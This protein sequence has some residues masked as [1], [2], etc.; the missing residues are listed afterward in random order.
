MKLVQSIEHSCATLDEVAAMFC[1]SIPAQQDGSIGVSLI[2][3]ENKFP[4]CSSAVII[5]LPPALSSQSFTYVCMQ[6]QKMG[7][8][9]CPVS[10]ARSV[11]I[12]GR[13]ITGEP[14]SFAYLLQHLSVAI[15]VGNVAS[16]LGSLP[17]TDIDQVAFS[18]C[19]VYSPATN[20]DLAA[21]S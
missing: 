14:S 2:H 20:D 1:N 16:I 7:V 19:R 21:C 8:N 6:S 11:Q 9:R 4:A 17:A 5:G 3:R 13:R 15:Q 18:L 12:F 10:C